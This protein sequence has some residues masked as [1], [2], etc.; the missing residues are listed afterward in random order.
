[1]LRCTRDWVS[2]PALVRF[3]RNVD[4]EPKRWPVNETSLAPIRASEVL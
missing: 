4:V 2:A 3:A 1:M